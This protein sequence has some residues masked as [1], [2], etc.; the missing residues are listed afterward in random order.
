MLT[1]ESETEISHGKLGMTILRSCRLWDRSFFLQL[2]L[3]KENKM[4]S[5]FRRNK[6]GIPAPLAPSPIHAQTLYC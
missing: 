1:H 6:W 2:L 5:V 3:D 4:C